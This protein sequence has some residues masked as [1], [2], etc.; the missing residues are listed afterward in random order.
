AAV[1]S[2]EGT[3]TRRERVETDGSIRPIAVS[4]AARLSFVYILII[5]FVALTV[6]LVYLWQIH[7]SPFFSTLMGDAR[8]Y[9]AWAQRIAGGDWIGRDVFYQAPLYPYALGVLYAIAGRSLVVV[10]ICQAVLGSIACGLLGAA[11]A[12]L[13]TP[14]T[15]LGAGLL[16]A[17]Y[18]PAIFFDGLLQ[19]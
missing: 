14:R 13:F 9:D 15:G 5:F 16:L 8:A 4:R 7:D 2:H 6:R 1:G 11:T 10:R 12:R 19:K 18:A 17:L 3:E